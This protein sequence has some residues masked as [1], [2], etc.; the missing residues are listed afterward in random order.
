MAAVVVA[1]ICAVGSTILIIAN[2]T[3]VTPPKPSPPEIT[4]MFAPS[5]ATAMT[6]MAASPDSAGPDRAT[7]PPRQAFT[8]SLPSM[9]YAMKTPTT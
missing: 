2:H 4:S 8:A 9:R 6:R 5:E 7:P 1:L 3:I